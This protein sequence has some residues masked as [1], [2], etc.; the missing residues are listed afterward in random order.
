MLEI[1]KQHHQLVL[2]GNRNLADTTRNPL[3][4]N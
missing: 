1:Q 3:N 4:A 2:K